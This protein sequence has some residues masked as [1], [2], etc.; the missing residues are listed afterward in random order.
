[1]LMLN[2]SQNTLFFAPM[3]GVTEEPYRLAILKNFPEWDYMSTDFLRIPTSA[4]LSEAKILEHY[5][6]EVFD[7]AE[8]KKKTIYQ[9]LTTEKAQTED[10]VEKIEALGFPWLDLNLGCPSK[11]VNSRGGGAYLLYDLVALKKILQTIRKTF[12]RTF[13]VKIRV[14]YKDDQSFEE[15]L[16]IIEGEGVEMVTIHGRT[17]AELYKGK[18]NWDYMKRAKAL[19]KI[20][21]IGNGDI[22]KLTDIDDFFSHTNCDGAM[23]GRAALK[24]PW[25]A[26]FYKSPLLNNDEALDQQRLAFIQIYFEALEKEFKK[27][28]ATDTFLLS[29]FKSFS[30]YLF[31]DLYGGLELR[32]N[33]LRSESF[34]EFKEHLY[35]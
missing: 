8:W 32:S 25:L 13:S 12:T 28:E 3:E 15:I 7:N 10:A 19:L 22:W 16:K 34:H 1:M 6:K 11:R 24:T 26:S 4:K 5:G 29:R 30:H 17:Q 31:N 23:F 18:A 27:V 20:P 14:G 2:L 9:I 21:V 33:L 35:S